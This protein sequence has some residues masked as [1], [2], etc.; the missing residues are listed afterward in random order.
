[1]K[2]MRERYFIGSESGLSRGQLRWGEQ[3]GRW[4]RVERDVYRLGPEP[5]TPLD[6]ALGALLATGSIAAGQLAALLQELDAGGAPVADLNLDM[7]QANTRTGIRRRK[8]YTYR[9]TEVQGF[10]CTDGLQTLVDLAPLLSDDEWEQALESALRKRLT[11]VAELD[12]ELEVLSASRVA[13][14][15]RMRRVLEHRPPGAPPTES[16]LETLGLQL[17]RLVPGLPEPTRQYDVVDEFGRFVA[18]V[19]LCWPELELFLELDG[20]KHKDQPVY[21][22]SRQTAVVAVTGWLVARLTWTE[23]VHH[24]NATV[25][26]LAQVLNQ[27]RAGRVS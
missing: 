18:R 3:Q 24:P 1:M 7:G 17:C 11:T 13:G 6:R 26:R 19:D 22:A 15:G 21:D 9:I 20:E 10:A 2:G 14:V 25:R 23:V 4:R 8:L 16:K 5:P 12:A 27:T